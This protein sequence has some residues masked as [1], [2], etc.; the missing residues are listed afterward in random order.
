[1]SR[2][3]FATSQV[4]DL[5]SALALGTYPSVGPPVSPTTGIHVQFRNIGNLTIGIDIPGV[6]FRLDLMPRGSETCSLLNIDPYKAY[7]LEFSFRDSDQVVIERYVT[8]CM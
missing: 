1:M 8:R 5:N 7:L 3:E 4:I 6:G 2:Y